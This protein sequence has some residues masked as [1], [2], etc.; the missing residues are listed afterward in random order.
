MTLLARG[1]HT[2]ARW[3]PDHHFSVTKNYKTPDL[4]D[5]GTLNGAHPEETR[6]P[7]PWALALTSGSSTVRRPRG[8]ASPQTEVSTRP[9]HGAGR[10]KGYFHH[11]PLITY[12]HNIHP[13]P[14]SWSRPLCIY[15][16]IHGLLTPDAFIQ[17][18]ATPRRPPPP[19]TVAPPLY[20]YA[21][22]APA[23]TNH[24]LCNPVK[25]IIS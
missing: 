22:S 25:V 3:R 2:H 19:P 7:R 6:R 21:A 15:T 11:T 17:H 14:E 12:H 8:P 5:A 9:Y 1:T 16:E 13:S 20:I 23:T 10:P 4:M 24:H 18:S